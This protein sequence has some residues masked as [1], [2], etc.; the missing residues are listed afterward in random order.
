MFANKARIDKKKYTLNPNVTDLME[1]YLEEYDGK[2]ERDRSASPNVNS[3]L[4]TDMKRAHRSDTSGNNN[5][6][7]ATKQTV[8]QQQNTLPVNQKEDDK[9]TDQK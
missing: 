5:D 7:K 2:S 4:Q 6:Q 3:L 1:K 8:V 9:S